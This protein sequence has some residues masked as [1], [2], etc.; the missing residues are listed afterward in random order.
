MHA[1]ALCP[2]ELRSH[3]LVIRSATEPLEISQLR[4]VLDEPRG[5]VPLESV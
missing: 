5:R 4:A 1:T 2:P 3:P